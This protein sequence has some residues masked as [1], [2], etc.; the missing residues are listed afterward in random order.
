VIGKAQIALRQAGPFGAQLGVPFGAGAGTELRSQ[1]SVLIRRCHCLGLPGGD[2]L[3]PQAQRRR[4]HIAAF[5]SQEAAEIASIEQIPEGGGCP[6][7][8][9]RIVSPFCNPG[10]EG[11]RAEWGRCRRGVSPRRHAAAAAQRRPA[12]P[13]VA[14]PGKALMMRSARQMMELKKRVER[15]IEDEGRGANRIY[16]VLLSAATTRSRTRKASCAPPAS[17]FS[18]SC[19]ACPMVL[20]TCAR[21]STRASRVRANA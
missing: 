12:R 3:F 4:M 11:A 13:R 9:P 19:S 15:E 8:V 17:P 7:D 14:V 2:S 20:V 16:P 18:K 6:S 5:R 1:N 21:H 10:A